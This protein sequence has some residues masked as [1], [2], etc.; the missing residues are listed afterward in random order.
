MVVDAKNGVAVE[1]DGEKLAHDGLLELGIA[2]KQ[3]RRHDAP[4]PLE[5]P[6]PHGYRT[7]CRQNLPTGKVALL[8]L[9]LQSRALGATAGGRHALEVGKLR[10]P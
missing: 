10:R 9:H 2:E 6:G 1:G 4:Q 7:S 5:L 8:F 3:K